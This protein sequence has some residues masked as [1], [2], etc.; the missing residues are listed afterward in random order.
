MDVRATVYLLLDYIA[1]VTHVFIFVMT[2]KE[3]NG[4]WSDCGRLKKTNKTLY[5]RL[6]YFGCFGL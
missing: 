6:V 1:E 3:M 2:F 5:F 4:L